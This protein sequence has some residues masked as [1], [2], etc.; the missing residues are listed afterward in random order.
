[1]ARERRCRR[2]R[3]APLSPAPPLPPAPPVAWLELNP[4]EPPENVSLPRLNSPPPAP[5]PAAPPAPPA[6]A[7]ALRRPHSSRADVAPAPSASV[8][9]DGL[10][11]EERIAGDGE[12]R[13][14]RVEDAA[15]LARG[16]GPAMAAGTADAR[17]SRGS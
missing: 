8:T 2:P 7:G 10:V 12:A 13:A 9:S 6:A 14:G 15:A 17:G 16:A 5:R 11:G 4:V 1:M 3:R